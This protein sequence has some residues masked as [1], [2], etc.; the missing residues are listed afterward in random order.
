MSA[1]GD[2]PAGPLAARGA[3]ADRLV[4]ARRELPL[5]RADLP[6]RQ[7]AA[8][9]AA[10]PRARQAPPARPLGHDTRPQSHLGAP[11]PAH[12]RARPQRA[13][14]DRSRSRRARHRGQRLPRGH[15]QRALCAGRPR[16]ARAP[17][18]L[19]PVLVPGRH[20]E[21]RGARDARVDP[22]GRR[23]RLC[24][25]PC[26]RSRLRQPGSD[27]RLRDR[28]RRGGD[29]AAGDE[30]ARQQVPQ[31][32]HRRRR[33]AHPAPQRLQDRE[34]DRARAHP[35]ARAARAADRLRLA[36]AVRDRRLRRRGSR[37]RPPAARGDARGGLRRDRSHPGHGPRRSPVRATDLA[38]DRAAHA[39]GLDVSEVR[40]RQARGGHLAGAPGAAH[41]G[42]PERGPPAAARGVDAE[43]PAG[44]ALRRVRA[45]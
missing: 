34:P 32:R 40:R 23:A 14:R 8:A 37:A 42:T 18:S 5:G 9:R 38:H 31:P 17:A 27:G 35:R 36:A 6:A 16:R 4:V 7:C 33:A 2:A 13:L 44:R 24:A 25:G 15:L 30:L 41:R 20:P 43:L 19:P 11:Q 29:R 26:L 21:P 22:R 3:A 39:E 28:R 10:R 12:R 1:S 45:R